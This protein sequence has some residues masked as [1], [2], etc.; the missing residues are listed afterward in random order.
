MPRPARVR[1]LHLAVIPTAVLPLL[2][3]LVGHSA[4]CRRCLLLAASPNLMGL[5][6]VIEM[7]TVGQGGLSP[8]ECLKRGKAFTRQKG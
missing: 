8:Q 4:F 3:R 5:K 7:A 2:R 6:R 1:V